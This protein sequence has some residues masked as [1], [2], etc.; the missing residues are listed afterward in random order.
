[1]GGWCYAES[2]LQAPAIHCRTQWD[3]ATNHPASLFHL[4]MLQLG[5]LRPAKW[6]NRDVNLGFL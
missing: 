2:L 1:M 3:G 4:T 6:L 5:K